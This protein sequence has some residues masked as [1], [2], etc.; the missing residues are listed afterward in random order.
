MS[1]KSI[2]IPNPDYYHTHKRDSVVRE[3]R[4]MFRYDT[5]LA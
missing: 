5:Y 4:M 3:F 1:D 2:T